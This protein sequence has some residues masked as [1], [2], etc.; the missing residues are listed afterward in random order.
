LEA[1]AGLRTHVSSQRTD[2]GNERPQ[3]EA[4]QSDDSELK[5]AVG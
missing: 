3:I 1:K 5:E 2:A 4:D